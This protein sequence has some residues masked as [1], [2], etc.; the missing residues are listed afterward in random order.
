MERSSAPPG[1]PWGLATE[2]R[3]ASPEGVAS[4]SEGLATAA[5]PVEPSMRGR[6]TQAR[7][8]PQPRRTTHQYFLKESVSR[9]ILTIMARIF[10]VAPGPGL[11]KTKASNY[12]F[13]T[14]PAGRRRSGRRLAGRGQ[15]RG[16]AAQGQGAGGRG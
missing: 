12:S 9:R 14:G 10:S 4:A 5:D 6:Q 13:F 11:V 16:R 7:T 15:R 3:L 2:S 1:A 8:T